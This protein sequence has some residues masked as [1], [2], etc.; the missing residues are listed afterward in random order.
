MTVDTSEQ[1]ESH[2]PK[3]FSTGK[4]GEQA[5]RSYRRKTPGGV[6]LRS[7]PR[8]NYVNSIIIAL[9]FAISLIPVLSVD[10]PAMNDYPTHLAR[11]YLLT[12]PTVNPFYQINRT[13]NPNLAMDLII[14]LLAHVVSVETATRLFYAVSQCLIFTGAIAA[15]YAMKRQHQLAGY[16]AIAMLYCAPFT[17]GLLNFEFGLGLA[18]WGFAFWLLVQDRALIIRLVCHSIVVVILFLSHFFALGIYGLTIGLYELWRIHSQAWQ[19]KR[20]AQIGLILA[21][22]AVIMLAFMWFSGASIGGS[23]FEW[24]LMW[25]LSSPTVF[26]SAYSLPLSGLCVAVLIIVW[27]VLRYKNA[28]VFLPPGKWIAA[29]YLVLYFAMP[30]RLFDSTYLELR[31]IV[32][33]I[34][35]LPACISFVPKRNW[36]FYFAASVMSLMAI[37]LTSK[38]FFVWQA[39]QPEYAKMRLSFEYIEP[40]SRILIG[41]NG[42]DGP[43]NFAPTLAVYYAGALVPSFFTVPAQQDVRLKREFQRFEVTDTFQYRPVPLEELIATAGDSSSSAS[44]SFV[45]H[46][47]SDFD[48]LYIVGKHISNLM[49][50]LLD[51]LISSERFTLYR[52]RKQSDVRQ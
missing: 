29:G 44:P 30:W 32:A 8:E 48:Y 9:L 10:M 31:V 1:G 42:S 38:V 26:M 20:L 22:P 45:R 5:D 50:D 36:Q 23:V 34:L 21:T 11:M 27:L 51:E 6:Q 43:M 40:K 37:V 52:I 2:S 49:P 28:V 4:D 17:L 12:T 41:D 18:L 24:S 15:E 13:L 3:P 14:P 33:A 25:K 16:T 47:V 7:P 39:Y 46:W 35:F 19:I